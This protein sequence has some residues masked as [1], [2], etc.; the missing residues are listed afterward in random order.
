MIKIGTR[1]IHI[2][3]AT[4]FLFLGF[5]LFLFDEQQTNAINKHI[6]KNIVVRKVRFKHYHCDSL[7]L[8]QGTGFPISLL[9]LK[10]AKAWQKTNF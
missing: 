4:F 8:L 6:N 10:R 2:I 1:L 5:L 3:A 9:F 7:R